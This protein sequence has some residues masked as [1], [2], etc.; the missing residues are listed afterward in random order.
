MP[1]EKPCN[2]QPAKVV[3]QNIGAENHGMATVP[4]GTILATVP[5]NRTVN[6][7]EIETVRYRIGLV[8]IVR[9]HF[10][11]LPV[12][13]DIG[14]CRDGDH[15]LLMDS[16][17]KLHKFGVTSMV[18]ETMKRAGLLLLFAAF[19]S[20]GGVKRSAG[21]Y[22]DLQ[23][24]L[25]RWQ[26]PVGTRAADDAILDTFPF[27]SLKCTGKDVYIS[28]PVDVVEEVCAGVHLHLTGYSS[29]RVNRSWLIRGVSIESDRGWYGPAMVTIGD[30]AGILT[31]QTTR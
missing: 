2:W 12:N 26:S 6:S 7:V 14:F 27:R 29:I 19:C 1:K 28:T 31:F 5:M 8:E 13:G 18:Q 25:S 23:A 4:V 9:K 3:S 22:I 15:I 17:R 20:C 24:E 30:G 11:I 10:L 21:G 16:H